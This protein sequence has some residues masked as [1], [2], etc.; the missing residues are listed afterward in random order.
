MLHG[1]ASLLRLCIRRWVAA[2]MPVVDLCVRAP[3]AQQD[4]LHLTH[5]TWSCEYSISLISTGEFTLS[6]DR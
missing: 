2:T 5:C 1:K 3:R 6:I 4:V